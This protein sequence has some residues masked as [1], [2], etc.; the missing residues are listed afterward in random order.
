MSGVQIPPSLPFLFKFYSKL[1][2]YTR[3]ISQNWLIRL[4]SPFGTHVVY[5]RS[6]LIV[7]EGTVKLSKLVSQSTIFL[8]FR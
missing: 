7:S 5:L 2:K 3:L 6:V 8:D 1:N 4:C